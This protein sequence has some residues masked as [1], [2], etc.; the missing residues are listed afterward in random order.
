MVQFQ[1]HDNF[2]SSV[3]ESLAKDDSLTSIVHE[4]YTGEDINNL[5]RRSKRIDEKSLVD[6]KITVASF[7]KTQ[8][9]TLKKQEKMKSVRPKSAKAD[10]KMKKRVVKEKSKKMEVKSPEIFTQAKDISAEIQPSLDLG[11]AHSCDVNCIF[12]DRCDPFSCFKQNCLNV[13]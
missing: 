4:K 13:P 7:T 6:R 10:E 8:T 11:K 2:D 5:K 12:D 1:S 3:V 9:P